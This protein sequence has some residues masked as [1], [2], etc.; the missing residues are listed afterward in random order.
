MPS[1]YLRPQTLPASAGTWQTYNWTGSLAAQA[2][3]S[4]ALPTLSATPG[5]H[6]VADSVARPNGVV[7]VNGGNN[8]ASASVNVYNTIG[9]TLPLATGFENAGALPPN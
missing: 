4:V 1:A 2:T 5:T 8:K 6:V 9:T 7:D 3:T